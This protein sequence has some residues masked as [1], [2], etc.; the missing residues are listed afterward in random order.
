MGHE[1]QKKMMNANVLIVG[2]SGLGVEIAKNII[3]AG[4]KSVTL[5][6][7]S[8]VTSFDCGANFYFQESDI[9]K[10]RAATCIGRLAELNQY[11]P[12]SLASGDTPDVTGMRVCVV[13]CGYEGKALLDLNDKC[14][15]ADCSF[16]MTNSCGVFGQIFVDNGKEFVVSDTDGEQPHTAQVSTILV[17]QSDSKKLTC[18]VL[19]DQGRHGLETGDV[20]KFSRVKGEC[21]SGVKGGLL[22]DIDI[23][24]DAWC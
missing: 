12:I 7:P 11:V 1:A 10:P 4:V 16:I 24:D 20:V 9:G 5:L 2:L 23:N 3:L 21:S 14:R 22:S 8:P 6:D 13:T 15:A 18:S 17:D 19:E